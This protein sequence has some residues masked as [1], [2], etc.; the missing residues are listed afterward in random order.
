MFWVIFLSGGYSF[1]KLFWYKKACITYAFALPLIPVI[2][3]LSCKCWIHHVG[4]KNC[5][6]LTNS[7]F[8]L[9][10]DNV[11]KFWECDKCLSKSKFSLP[12]SHLDEENWLLFNNLEKSKTSED[13]NIISADD[14]K[15][16]EQC[17]YIQNLVDYINDDDDVDD[18]GLLNHINSKYYYV[19]H[20]NPAKIDFP[21]SFGFFHANIASLNKHIDDLRHILSLLSYKFDVIGISEHKIR[22]DFPASNNITIP[23]YNECIY[24]PTET[25]HGGTGFYIKNIISHGGTG[26]YIKNIISHGGTGFYIKNI[27]SHG[28]TGF[29]IKNTRDYITRKDLQLNS[30]GDF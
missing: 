25:S 21:S 23:G 3:C 27:I 6:G 12:F 24:E 17:E 18:D 15:F 5:S 14:R 9:H 29:Y 13:V 19:K 11:S 26:F 8:K 30:P 20:L 2:L 16:A 1:Y 7:E 4:R 28:G 22:K 10:N